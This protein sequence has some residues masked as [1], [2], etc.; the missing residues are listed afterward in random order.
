[1]RPYRYLMYLASFF[2]AILL[3]SNIASS[4]ILLLGP[5]SFDGGTIL[6]P[7][8]YIFSDVLTEVYGYANNRKVIWLGFSC[9][10]LMSLVLMFVTYLP[11]APDW[12]GQAAFQQVLGI[13][14]RI[15]AGSLLAYWL[16]N[17]TNSY[18]LAK[19][20]IWTAGRLLFLRTIS[21]TLIGEALDTAVFVLVAFYGVL[22][23]ELLTSVLIS[24]YI[25]KCSVEIIFTP[26]TYKVVALLKKAEQEDFYDRETNFNPFKL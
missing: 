16:G 18:I 14:P 20:K 24:N 12:T 10:L 26:I 22:S 23:P 17:F 2:V 7:L 25:F 11:S 9:A 4:K 15:V 21:S 1:M 19:I 5:F 6:F 8:S 13:T 3:I